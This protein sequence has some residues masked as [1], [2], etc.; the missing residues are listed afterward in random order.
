L[1]VSVTLSGDYANTKKGAPTQ[2]GWAS[3]W[4]IGNAS[5]LA[6]DSRANISTNLGEVHKVRNFYT[7]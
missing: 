5:F 4:M 3:T 1:A 2:A 6:D 7:T